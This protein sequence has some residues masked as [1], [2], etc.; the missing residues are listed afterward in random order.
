[1][2]YND[3]TAKVII[4]SVIGFSMAY[5]LKIGDFF[6]GTLIFS[7]SWLEVVIGGV[8]AGLLYT[9]PGLIILLSLWDKLPGRWR[10]R[11]LL[12]L[13]TIIAISTS[14]TIYIALGMV[15]EGLHPTLIYSHEPP[16]R[17][18]LYA[19]RIFPFAGIS[20]LMGIGLIMIVEAI[21]SRRNEQGINE[22]SS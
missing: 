6:V 5:F 3:L 7:S 19:L 13:W 11:E 8:M 12:P 9:L 4:G 10:R 14:L 16:S 17:V 18:A 15:Y 1:M 22:D 21:V 2:G 20:S